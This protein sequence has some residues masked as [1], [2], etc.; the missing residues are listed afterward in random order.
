MCFV[1]GRKIGVQ[2][3]TADLRGTNAEGWVGLNL[4]PHPLEPKGC[5]TQMPVEML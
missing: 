2:L 3:Q 1:I 4:N 5:G